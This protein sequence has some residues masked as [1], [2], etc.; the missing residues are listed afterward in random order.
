MP[1]CASLKLSRRC[2]HVAIFGSRGVG[3]RSSSWPL[4]V[5]TTVLRAS[6]RAS[7]HRNT[8]TK[9]ARLDAGLT[10]LIGPNYRFP[11]HL[12]HD[13]QSRKYPIS[14]RFLP[15]FANLFD[16][17]NLKCQ[18]NSK[19]R[20]SGTSPP[21]SMNSN[22]GARGTSLPWQWPR[23]RRSQPGPRRTEFRCGPVITGDKLE[24]IKSPR[25]RR[26][27]AGIVLL[28]RMSHSWPREE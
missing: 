6:G 18:M 19:T 25:S 1:T 20:I 22:A 26:R 5:N 23:A 15:V 3:A 24:H 11:K 4:L 10:A 21:C 14:C 28:S 27:D 9:V 2:Q 16:P 13:D 7:S 17:V 8:E 12:R